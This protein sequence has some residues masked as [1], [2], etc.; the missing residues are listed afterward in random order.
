MTWIQERMTPWTR[1]AERGKLPG[2]K[3]GGVYLIASFESSPP[4]TV[5]PLDERIVCIGETGYLPSRLNQFNRSVFKGREEHNPAITLR[6]LGAA[7]ERSLYVSV[8]A[9]EPY[10]NPVVRAFVRVAERFLIWQYIERHN[11]LPRANKE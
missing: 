3:V 1:W 7:N 11:R 4:E 9:L 5:D 6:E 2:A 8:L 10:G